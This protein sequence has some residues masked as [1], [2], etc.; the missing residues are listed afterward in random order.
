MINILNYANQ[1]NIGAGMII[2][3]M[4]QYL[5]GATKGFKVI[6]IVF[7]SAIML[8]IYIIH[9]IMNIIEQISFIIPLTDSKIEFST[10]SGSPA[11]T[12]TLVL[13]SLISAELISLLI[14]IL[15]KKI[16][17]KVLKKLELEDDTTTKKQ[18]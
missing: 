10:I 17:H 3:A 18:D 4:L 15:P 7:L 16:K 13:S 11:Y 12:F 1:I 2:G 8:A 14:V 9:P 6:L 5:L